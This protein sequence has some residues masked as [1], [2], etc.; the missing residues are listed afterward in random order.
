LAET[1]IHAGC[2][3]SSV[4]SFP[5]DR[6]TN[7]RGRIRNAICFLDSHSHLY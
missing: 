3:Y 6:V 7:L 2:A 5:P 4:R 1:G